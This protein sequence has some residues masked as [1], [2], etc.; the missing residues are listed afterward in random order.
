[1]RHHARD[2]TRAIRGGVAPLTRFGLASR[3]AAAAACLCLMGVLEGAA[4]S[5]TKHGAE[6]S[7]CNSVSAGVSPPFQ[8]EDAGHAEPEVAETSNAPAVPVEIPEIDALLAKAIRAGRT[9]GAVVLVGRRQGVIFR[10][11]Y[12]HRAIIPVREE[13]TVDTIFDVASLTKPM[14]V[15]PLVQ[16]LLEGGRLALRDPAVR[17][18]PEFAARDK[19]TVTIEQLL[20]HTS[21]LPPT[22]S[23]ND[24]KLGAERARALT[25]GGWL[26]K[27]PGREFI[28]SDI[29]FIALGELIE[30]VAGERLDQLAEHVLWTPLGMS[31]TRYCPTPCADPRV[32]PTELNYGWAKNPIRGEP[33]DTRAHRLGGVAGH[34][35]VFSTGDDIARYARMVLGEGELDGA[36][37]L[38]AERVRDMLE[39]R[40]VPKAKR[41]L[42]WDVSSGFSSGRGRELSERAVGHS[43]YTGT[44]LWVDPVLDLFVIFL[45]NRNHPFSTGK[46]TDLQGQVTDLAVRAL[47]PE[48]WH[49]AGLAPESGPAELAARATPAANP[50]REISGPASGS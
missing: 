8:I 44:S 4:R 34:A 29:G 50:L 21:G 12:G 1:M 45:S 39:P 7:A 49:S 47:Y 25:L 22:N 28:Y 26:Y 9:P 46:V 6:L 27:Y 36:R 41:A 30:N 40:P 5:T 37:V 10:R 23:L 15:A 17:Y 33:S 24:F 43:G 3:W 32:A 42:G 19:Q 31:D 20:L 16:W 13:M 38:S 14:V 18:L 35:G 48:G 2:R 11:A